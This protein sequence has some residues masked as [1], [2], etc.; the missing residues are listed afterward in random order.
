MV[1]TA[2]MG[3][4]ALRAHRYGSSCPETSPMIR[5]KYWSMAVQAANPA[6]LDGQVRVANPKAALFTVPM[7]ANRVVRAKPGN[8][9]MLARQAP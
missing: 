1:T 2:V 9:V 3:I 4:R 8:R 6:R 7:A 5:S